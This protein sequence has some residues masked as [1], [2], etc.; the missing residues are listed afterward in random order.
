MLGEKMSGHKADCWLV[1]TGWS[2]G[3]VGTGQRIKLRHTRAIVSAALEGQLAQVPFDR[4]P[5][6]GLMTPRSCPDVPGEVLTPRATW[7]DKAAY[8]AKAAQL[9]RLF[10]QNF[11]KFDTASAQV[12]ASG[13]KV[14]ANA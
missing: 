7:G 8:D 10:S 4:D 2:G 5:I 3:G 12:A 11:A 13:P 1:N 9:A 14:S 6:F